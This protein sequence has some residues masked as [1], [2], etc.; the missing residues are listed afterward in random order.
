MQRTRKQNQRDSG[1][2]TN[3]SQHLFLIFVTISF[4]LPYFPPHIKYTITK[5]FINI[6]IKKTWAACK[7]SRKYVNPA[8]GCFCRGPLWPVEGLWRSQVEEP[9]MKS[10]TSH[11]ELKKTNNTRVSVQTKGQSSSFN[12]K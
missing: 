11:S 7:C 6:H 1:N 3:H 5:N 4:M 8:S 12:F 10:N 2:K 9:Q